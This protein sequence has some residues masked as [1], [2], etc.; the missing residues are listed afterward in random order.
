[1]RWARRALQDGGV[2]SRLTARSSHFSSNTYQ[3]F[4]MSKRNTLAFTAALLMAGG[5]FA[6][7]PVN[8][9][10]T[11]PQPTA[12]EQGQPRP[13]QFNPAGPAGAAS[14]PAPAATTMT[15]APAPAPAPAPR[16]PRADRG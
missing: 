15:T 6:Q 12:T 13:G 7:A 4:N 16:A 9:T 10:T 1:V 14:Q 5:A 2:W 3:E 11:P 8:T